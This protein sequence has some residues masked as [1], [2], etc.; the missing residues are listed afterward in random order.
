MTNSKNFPGY[1]FFSTFPVE[2]VSL[3]IGLSGLEIGGEMERLSINGFTQMLRNGF[4][5]KVPDV[6]PSTVYV[7]DGEFTFN[8]T[9]GFS[10]NGTAVVS[11]LLKFHAKF[12]A[13]LTEGFFT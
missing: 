13:D 1:D 6:F 8:P 12:N 11:E 5:L 9:G 7:D 10:F 2:N 4:K 3:A